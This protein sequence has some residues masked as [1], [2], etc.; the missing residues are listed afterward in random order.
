MKILL[1][2]GARPN[3]MKIASIIDA[4]NAHNVSI[5]NSKLKIQHCLVHTGQ[6][7]DDSMSEAF[8]R[9]LDLP[10]PDIHLEVGSASHA[11]QTAE[12]M[13]RFEPVLLKEQSDVVMVVGDVNS[14][15]A[16]S[17]VAAK[18]R[19]NS[20]QHGNT[21]SQQ[22]FKGLRP[23][24]AH[25][26]SGLRSFDRSMPEEINRI[27]T[28][29]LSDFLFVSE[30]S[31][32]DNLKNEG[33]KNFL[34][35]EDVLKVDHTSRLAPHALPVVAFVGNT[36][37]DTL[38]KHR[39]LAQK[40]NI[41]EKLGL[42]QSGLRTEDS[43]VSRYAIL[44]LHR[45]SNVD[46][47]ETFQEIVEALSVISKELPIFFP[48]HPRT[49]NRIKEFDFEKYFNVFPLNLTLKTEHSTLRIP[50]ST[51][52][53]QNSILPPTSNLQPPA[54]GI[55]CLEPLGYL[56]FL[57]LMSNAK[58]VLTDSGGIQEETTVL[59][60]PC[61]TLRENTERPVTITHGTN[62]LVGT[63]KEKIIESAFFQLNGHK[64]YIRNQL[65]K[66]SKPNEFI[67]WNAEPI[68][69][70]LNE[71]YKPN[72]PNRLDKPDEPDQPK[73]PRFWDGHAGERI[74]NVLVRQTVG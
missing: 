52:N 33:F 30:Q 31:G 63:N 46:D 14:T 45:P 58:L 70:G 6:H 47:K 25:V 37:I 20:R 68:S 42:K 43:G 2:A 39:G 44:T 64:Q 1:V 55:H 24:I 73:R 54:S 28:D 51:L 74:I 34:Y 49:I 15:V 60:I 11:V 12:I 27:L 35:A 41:L 65:N 67:P 57:C 56:D 8:F 62:I 3:F 23:L 19:Y 13:K 32:L 7:Y 66:P 50:H 36:M 21:A 38:L 5:Q 71:P 69:L 16:C 72:K 9:D 61:V 53:T 10:E 22:H 4:I 26:E 48:V 17:L 29:Q 59:G 40:S 18:I